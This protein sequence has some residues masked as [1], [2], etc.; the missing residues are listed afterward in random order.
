MY[1]SL[2]FNT[3]MCDEPNATVAKTVI[4]V[5]ACPTDPWSAKPILPNRGWGAALHV[6]PGRSG[7]QPG[8]V[9]GA[10]VY[11]SV[12]P[13]HP[14]QCPSPAPIQP[15]AQAIGVAKGGVWEPTTRS[16]TP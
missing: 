15:L 13:T 5:F 4:P 16:A 1:D 6:F 8:R 11:G 7:Y 14:D 2:N 10:L 3:S 12:G 9:D